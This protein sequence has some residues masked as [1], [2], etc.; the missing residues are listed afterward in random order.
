MIERSGVVQTVCSVAMARPGLE[1][2][3]EGAL[4]PSLRVLAVAVIGYVWVVPVKQAVRWVMPELSPGS[5][6]E[7][8]SELPE[9]A[10]LDSKVSGMKESFAAVSAAVG[11]DFVAG[12]L[13]RCQSFEVWPGVQPWATLEKNLVLLSIPGVNPPPIQDAE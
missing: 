9:T 8:P 2:E 6:Q 3:D 7:A 11:E 13:V 1:A 5:A 4:L 10:L 12:A